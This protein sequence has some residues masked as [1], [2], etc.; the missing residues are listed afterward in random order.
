MVDKGQSLNGSMLKSVLIANRGEIAVRAASTLR[1]MG[2]RSVAVYSSAD[3]HSGHVSVAD[4]AIELHGETPGQIY[5]RS[6]LI[7]E[8]ARSANVQGIFP[9]YGFLSENAQFAIDCE[10]AG[11]TFIGPTA[12]Q[13]GQFGL[14]HVAYEIALKANLPLLPHSTLLEDIEEAKRQGNVIGYPVMLKSTAGS[15]GNGMEKCFDEKELIHSFE[16]VSR[17]GEKFFKNSGVYLERY[18]ANARHIEV[19]IFGD[20]QGQ[21][22]AFAERDCSLQRRNQKIVEETPAN[23]ISDKIREELRQAAIRLGKSVNYCSAGTVEFV[24]DRNSEQFYF[25]EVN[26]RLQVISFDRTNSFIS[27]NL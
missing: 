25:L 23:G 27:F 10:K 15:S 17:A 24:Y 6:D 19:Q 21:V 7:I 3:R 11:I 20:G 18:I 13:I 22:V 2:I 12:E 1:K 9:G 5:L 26:C 14:K 16:K 4:Q 8:A